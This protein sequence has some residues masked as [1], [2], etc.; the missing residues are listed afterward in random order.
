VI[1]LREEVK[2]IEGFTTGYVDQYSPPCPNVPRGAPDRIHGFYTDR[3][4]FLTA[5]VTANFD[6]VLYGH[7][8]CT[9]AVLGGTL[10]C[11]D[12][13]HRNASETISF[14]MTPN[15]TRHVVVDGFDASSWGSY[16]L[17]VRFEPA[18]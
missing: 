6:V 16:T 9:S 1:P 2:R 8:D 10:A 3:S 4:G 17:E 15:T 11:S 18:M 12:G 14:P 13:A 7:S 5:T